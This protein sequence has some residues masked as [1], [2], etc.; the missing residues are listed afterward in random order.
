MQILAS[1]KTAIVMMAV[2]AVL[3]AVATIIEK[4][5]GT[6]VAKALIYYSP[7]FLLLQ[8]LMV[9]N[10][11]CIALDR[12]LVKAHKW[13]NLLVH[14][15]FIVILTGAAIT[16]FYSKDG[17]LSIREGEKSSELIIKEGAENYRVDQLPFEVELVDFRLIR[18]PGSSSP[19]SY[20]SDL[21]IHV[22]GQ[23]LEEKVYMNHVLDMH[24]YRF[25]QASYDPDEKGTILSVS[26]DVAGRTV[27]YI[28]YALLLL[29]FLLCL[30]GKNTRFRS[31]VRRLEKAM[32]VALLLLP[33]FS[34]WAGETTDG[35]KH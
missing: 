31:L 6:D 35:Q 5:S 18:Y 3:M 12:K 7:L 33:G 23:Q 14:G 26:Y 4:Y 30:F 27:T 15:A 29:G 9:V 21:V 22:D 19:S 16:H 10:Y 17:I 20:E 13:G 1:Y 24:G 25:F 32:L 28:G 11:I 2:Y 34:S 8:L